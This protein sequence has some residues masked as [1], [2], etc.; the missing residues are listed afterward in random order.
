VDNVEEV[1]MSEHLWVVVSGP[2]PEIDASPNALLDK[3]KV[4]GPF[5]SENEA[6]DYL[7]AT[8]Y[9][10][11]PFEAGVYE[12]EEPRSDVEKPPPVEEM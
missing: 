8:G 2:R 10:Q 5:E 11:T 7:D 9:Y 3:L 1:E 4:E 12:V 6:G